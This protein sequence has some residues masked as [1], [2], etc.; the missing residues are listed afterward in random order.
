M[1]RWLQMLLP[2]VVLAGGIFGAWVLMIA[3]PGV[4]T[5]SPDILPPLVR[6]VEAEMQT[7]RLHVPSQGTVEPRTEVS[8]VPEVAGRVVA[9]S[10]SLV[11]GGFF[12]RR[13]SVA[14]H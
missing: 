4:E 11:D 10:P 2:L 3:H 14:E 13:R 7:V 8:L 9:V 5:R 1:K 12:S 6:L